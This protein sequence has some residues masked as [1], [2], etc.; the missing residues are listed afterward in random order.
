KSP[1]R[2]EWQNHIRTKERREK[3]ANHFKDP[4]DPFKIAIVRDMWLTGFDVPSLHTMYIDKPMQ[5]HGLMQA[6][7]RVNRVYGDKPGGLIVD[8]LGLAYHLQ[9]ALAVYTESGGK[10]N[11]AIDQSEA[12]ALTLREYEIC[13][14]LFY[15]FDWSKWKSGKGDEQLSLM[16]WAQDHIL[17][18]ENGKQRYL[19][20]VTR[21]S[22]AFA[23]A[24]PNEKVLAIRDDVGFFQAVRARIIKSSPEHELAAEDVEHAIR[25]IISRAVA[26]EE[27]IDIFKAAGLKKPD[28]SILSDE[29]LAD[30]QNMPQRN[31]AIELLRKLL[32]DE[33]KL[34]SRKNLVQSRSFAEMLE[35]TIRSYQNRAIEVA[36]VI[37]ELIE[38]AKEMREASKRGEALKLTEDEL[39]F[40]DALEVNDSAV[41]VLGDDTLKGIAREL[42]RTVHENASID[43]TMKE[44]V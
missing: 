37:A 11:T 9:Q 15:K 1:H 44:S 18:L 30:V 25:Q 3:L 26:S 23:L 6:I 5:G 32:N 4:K 10:G 12:V 28:I 21:L 31:V 22:Q 16:N 14:D 35:R 17:G 7:A 13:R 41:K 33:I 20:T 43:W 38:L 2:P 40:Y 34:R 8:Y 39:A 27:V 29:F 24:V 19:Q 42:V 36:E